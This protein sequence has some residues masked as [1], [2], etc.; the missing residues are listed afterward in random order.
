MS[1]IKTQKAWGIVVKFT[2]SD[3]L[4][5]YSVRITRKMCI[6][7]YEEECAY[8]WKEMKDV[9]CRKITITY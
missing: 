9:E 2:R 7:D 5:P 3:L 8:T 1:K 4:L 6:K